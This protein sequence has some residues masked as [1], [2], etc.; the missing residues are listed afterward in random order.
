MGE[1]TARRMKKVL[2]LAAAW[3]VVAGT[4]AAQEPRKLTFRGV[5]YEVDATLA[6]ASQ[7][8]VA[9]AKVDFEAVSPSGVVEV[10][11]H[12]NLRIN[13]VT[14]SGGKA[15]PFERDS[16]T[17][18]RVRV[19]LP[20]QVLAGQRT[21]LT[22]DYAGP[23]ANDENSPV[24]GIQL[25]NIS[26]EGSYL[27]L[28]A[29]WFPLTDYPSN[30]Y[31]AVFN[32]VVPEDV[33]V[34]GTGRSLAP[35]LKPLG[36]PAPAKRGTAAPATPATPAG[37]MI[38]YTFRTERPEPAGSFVAG[39]L[40]LFPVKSEGLSI[41]VYAPGGTK[42]TATGYGESAA[43]IINVFSEQF[44]ALPQPNIT[45]AQMPAEAGSVPGYAAPG[46]LLVS[47]RQW[48][49]KV[50][51]RLLAQLAAKQW[52]ESEVL[53]ASAG[54]V[55]LSD[56]LSRYSEALYFRETA[57]EE[58]FRRALED[59]AIGAVM[60]EDAAPIAQAARLEPFSPEYRSVVVN[61]GALV[62]HMLRAQLGEAAFDALLKEYYAAG[63]GKSARIEDF[64]KLA[65]ARV[66]RPATGNTQPALGLTPFFA[67]WLNSTGIPE[68]KLD[69]VVYRTQKGFKTVGKVRQN[70]ETFRMPVEV[71]IETEGN[72][73]VKTIEVVGTESDF[74]IETFGRPK[75]NGIRLDPN[76]QLLTASTS[77]RV[78]ALIARGEELAEAGRFYD[79]TQEYQR[80]LELQS[81]NS[82]A[83][84]RLGEAAFFQKNW[85]S[86]ANTFRD[87]LLGEREASSNWVE[88]WSHIYLG[89][90]YDLTGD[91]TRA[92]HEYTK[93]RETNDDTGGA[94]AEIARL[95]AQ[96]YQEEPR[97]SGT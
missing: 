13:A 28:P 45:V 50:N 69:Y 40:Q 18:L 96:P 41:S 84:F 29:R 53:P 33:A 42:E 58:G 31:T 85:Q 8:L 72:P 55:W 32:I 11:L 43:K 46:L 76:H 89:K 6:P 23:L 97:K 82:L 52:W 91:R 47:R 75:P 24:K 34:V 80:A 64:Q 19:T 83:L 81:K 93:A 30:R 70:L 3:L 14:D 78:R 7:T 66:A 77:L 92:V 17:P 5:H 57:G 20:Q 21:T 79:A 56:G 73:E 74:V 26:A 71:K 1:L 44:G 35:T 94:Q 49:E 51:D 4:A 38:V 25:A 68:F 67:Q 65:Q 62:F 39:N 15:V 16:D 59:M 95:L 86:A 37:K 87:A 60:F 9:R 63:A 2:P 27:L 12:P 36:P 90:I 54:D 61:K 88:V 10:E 48:T 22:F